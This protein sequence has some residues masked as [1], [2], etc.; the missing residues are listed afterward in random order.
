MKILIS[1]GHLTP[2]L[3]VIDYIRRVDPQTKIVFVGRRQS[4]N[5]QQSPEKAEVERRGLKFISLASPRIVGYRWGSTVWHLP[6]LV[7]AVWRAGQ[8]IK[9]ERPQV[10]LSFGG[11][12]AV[13]VAVAAWLNKIPIVTH[14]QTRVL[15]I[16]NK[17]IAQLARQV[18]ISFKPTASQ[19]PGG[20]S[21]LT[22]N[23]LRPKLLTPAQR[24]PER[25]A[26]LTHKPI[27]YVTGGSQGARFINKLIADNL[28]HLAQQ[29]TIIHQA[30]NPRPGG[31]DFAALSALKENL[32]VSLKKRYVVAKW[33][34]ESELAWIYH[35]AR[36]VVARAG[37]NTVQE[38]HFFALPAVL[39]PLPRSRYGEQ[40]MNARS[41]SKLGGAV[42][43]DQ[44]EVTDKQ[45]LMKLDQA[46]QKYQSMQKK[47]AAATP[48]L[49]AEAA[50]NIYLLIKQVVFSA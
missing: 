4:Q 18:A 21:V 29:W 10:F 15:G 32:P 19:V 44:D 11:Y 30:G 20:K 47:L 50:K 27:L 12:L 26:D 8:I 37:A 39:I 1:G 5:G 46:G 40:L 33:F 9:K 16:A 42:V 24:V 41:L 43:L 34:S 31:Y 13:P 2:A 23:P 45:F 22:G 7:L 48:D 17:L 35:H 6:R 3:A 38:L 25:F 49:A 36:L 14:E 28:E